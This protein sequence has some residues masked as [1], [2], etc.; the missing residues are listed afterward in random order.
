MS[1]SDKLMSVAI[2]YPSAPRKTFRTEVESILFFLLTLVFFLYKKEKESSNFN[3]LK[4]Y[5]NVF[6]LGFKIKE[7]EKRIHPFPSN[8]MHG[9]KK[10]V[11]C[12]HSI[13]NLPF[14]DLR[15]FWASIFT[16]LDS[17]WCS[18]CTCFAVAIRTKEAST[19]IT[20]ER[21]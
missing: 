9:F 18:T 19:K 5:E 15:L 2:R 11:G 1:P 20:A 12:A 3:P 21:I 4:I 13:M 6:V 10:Q 16:D 7:K 8:H 17:S 14:Y